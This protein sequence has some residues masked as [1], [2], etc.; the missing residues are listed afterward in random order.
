MKSISIL[1]VRISTADQKTDRQRVNESNYDKVIEDTCSGSIPMFDRTGGIELKKLIDAGVV[2]SISVWQIDRCGRDLRDIIN[3]IYYTAQRKVPIHFISQG[4]VT[5]D[6]K[7]EENPISKMIISILGVVAEMERKLSRR[8]S[9]KVL[10][11]PNFRIS[12][13]EENLAP[14]KIPLLS[15]PNLKIERQLHYSKRGIS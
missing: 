6:D 1:Y 12:I 8:G 5:L 11:L 14:K 7:G 10:R 3:F 4:L 15:Y 13:W 2:G 9:W